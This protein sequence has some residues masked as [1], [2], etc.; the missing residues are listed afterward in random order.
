MHLLGS[1][2][3]VVLM[4]GEDADVERTSVSSFAIDPGSELLIAPPSITIGPL[5]S[6]DRPFA[7]R[8]PLG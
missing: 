4:P 7:L 8:K 6:L 2:A 3:Y 5:K 1:C